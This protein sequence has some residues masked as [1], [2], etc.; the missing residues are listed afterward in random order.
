MGGLSSLSRALITDLEAVREKDSWP[1]P[2]AADIVQ[3]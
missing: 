2:Y 3:M 1:V